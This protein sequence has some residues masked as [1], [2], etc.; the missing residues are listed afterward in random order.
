MATVDSALVESFSSLKASQ[1][2]D[3][4]IKERTEIKVNS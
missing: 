3:M 1:D 4:F 2:R